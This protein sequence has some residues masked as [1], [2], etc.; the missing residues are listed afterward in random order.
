MAIATVSRTDRGTSRVPDLSI[1]VP[2]YRSEECL[3]ALV[4][5]IA[6]SL[7][8]TGWLFEVILVNDFSPDQSWQVIE[9]LCRRYDFVVGVDLRRNF[10]QDNAILTGVRLSRGRYVAVMDDDLQHHPRF[11]PGM[12]ARAEQGADVVYADFTSK[13]QK[14]WKNLGSWANGKLAEWLLYKPRGIYLSPYKV[15]SRDIADAIST[16][17]GPSPYVDGLLF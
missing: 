4:T 12:V 7:R 8:H 1:V 15:I 2:V 3:R 11:L 6:A 10:G 5:E 16:F 9:D 17:T 13:K 14:L